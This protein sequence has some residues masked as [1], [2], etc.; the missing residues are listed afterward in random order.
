MAIQVKTA[1]E[2]PIFH[3][4]LSSGLYFLR[5]SVGLL[6]KPYESMRKIILRGNIYE[7]FPIALLILSYFA[8]ASLV[9]APA[10][11]PY[12]LTKHYVLLVSA[13]S[14]GFIVITGTILVMARILRITIQHK[15][16]LVGWSYTLLPTVFWF[17]ITSILYVILPPPRTTAFTGMLFSGLYLL[18]SSALLFWKLMLIYLVLR[19]TFREKL[20]ILVAVGI[21]IISVAA[22]YSLFMYR[23]GIFR[24]PFI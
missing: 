19:F 9:R 16:L 2:Y 1:V 4:I 24:I 20:A 17:L 12:L 10:F 18:F 3:E 15:S 13:S 7:C 22:M 6:L 14:L 11:R 5:S 23:L 21:A 8:L